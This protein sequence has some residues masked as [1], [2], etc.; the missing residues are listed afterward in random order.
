MCRSVCWSAGGTWAGP[1]AVRNALTKP[2]AMV[3]AAAAVSGRCLACCV[4]LS[5]MP[6]FAVISSGFMPAPIAMRAMR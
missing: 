2:D 5:G 4:T 3:R 1:S 6:L